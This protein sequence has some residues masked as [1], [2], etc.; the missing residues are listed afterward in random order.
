MIINIPALIERLK[1]VSK[2]FGVSLDHGIVS[3]DMLTLIRTARNYPPHDAHATGG[4]AVFL[5]YKDGNN[6]FTL[7]ASMEEA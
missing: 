3:V 5:W 4:N 2:E 1:S 7:S 6:I